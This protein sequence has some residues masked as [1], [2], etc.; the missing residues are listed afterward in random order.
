MEWFRRHV[1]PAIGVIGVVVGVV[2]GLYTWAESRLSTLT[3]SLA[4]TRLDIIERLDTHNAA[5]RA[6]LSAQTRQLENIASSQHEQFAQREDR[7][8]E[9]ETEHKRVIDAIHTTL[10]DFH[11]E[12]GKHEAAHTTGD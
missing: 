11:F 7:F 5:I 12:L 4:E 2:I 1:V 8:E 3:G 10:G 9:L 6:E